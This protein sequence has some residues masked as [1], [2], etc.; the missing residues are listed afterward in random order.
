M[1]GSAHTCQTRNPALLMRGMV[2]VERNRSVPS[3]YLVGADAM[4]LLATIPG[5][6]TVVLEQQDT[7]RATIS[8]QWKDSGSHS[9]GIDTIFAANGMR[10]VR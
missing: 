2:T 7:R 4:A 3:P 5:V 10:V 8:F 1:H 9:A 6:T